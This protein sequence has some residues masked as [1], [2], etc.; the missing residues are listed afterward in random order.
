MARPKWF[1]NLLKKSF[2][3]R[4]F[5]AR[6][7]KIPGIKYIAYKLLFDDDIIFY[8]PRDKVIA[9]NKSVIKKIKVDEKI[10]RHEDLV[11]PSKIIEKFIDEAKYLWVMNFCLCRDANKCETY[12]Q[13]IG[14]LFM[15]EAVQKIDPDFG[16]LVT[17]EE[18]KEHLKKCQDAGLIHLVGKNKI[19][20]QWLGVKPGEKLLTVCNCCE[21]CCLWRMLPNLPGKISR[22]VNKLPGIKI[23]VQDHCSG[24]GTCADNFCFVKAIKMKDDLAVIY[25]E[26]CRGCGRCIEVCPENAI[27]LT[28]EDG[29]YINQT[30]KRISDVVS[31]E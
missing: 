30:I 10:A 3:L 7:T 17:K 14:C 16:Q 28:I 15:G 6:L 26:M 29:E 1:V 20:T 27:M 5:L 19:D 2:G 9:E 22:T 24:C 21:C 8:L 23:E 31:V 4:F 25:Q 11:V 18:A 13:E 12:P